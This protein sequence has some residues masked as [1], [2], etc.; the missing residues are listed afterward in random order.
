M[1]ALERLEARW[2]LRVLLYLLE[3][4]EKQFIK[5]HEE[6]RIP[7][8]TLQETLLDLHFLSLLEERRQIPQKRYI[9]LSSKGKT[10][11]EILREINQILIGNQKIS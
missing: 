1:N 2:R 3:K 6:L 9:S 5:I 7:K 10:V 4:G 8:Q 11:A